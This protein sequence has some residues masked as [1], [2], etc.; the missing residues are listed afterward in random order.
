MAD[1]AIK[2]LPTPVE[3]VN[4]SLRTVL[5]SVSTRP[6]SIASPVTTCNKPSGIP[7]C[8]ARSA[9]AKAVN[10]VSGAGFKTTAQP[11]AK[12][13]AHLRVIMAAGKFQG[14]IAATT[15]TG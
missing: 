3:P 5:L 6:I 10:G 8:C 9:K 15:P 4:E 11:A 13:G 14:V 12:A 1:C 2:S 7:A